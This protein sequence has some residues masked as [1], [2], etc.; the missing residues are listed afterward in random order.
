MKSQELLTERGW[1]CRYD[2]VM[3]QSL[4]NLMKEEITGDALT[5]GQLLGPDVDNCDE[6][7]TEGNKEQM[8]VAMVNHL[9]IDSRKAE[10]LSIRKGFLT[11]DLQSHLALFTVRPSPPRAR[12]PPARPLGQPPGLPLGLPLGSACFTLGGCRVTS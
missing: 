8:V 5:V 2:G 12:L 7:V 11:V 6:V 9:L 10:L 3:A 4:R 1:G